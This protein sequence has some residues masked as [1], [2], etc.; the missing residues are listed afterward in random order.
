MSQERSEPR[1]LGC[2]GMDFHNVAFAGE[3]EPF[4]PDRQCAQHGYALGD[5]IAWQVR[6][7]MDD[8]AERSKTDQEDA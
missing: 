3:T 4:R 8:V 1:H 7:F 6:V 5:F 2:Y